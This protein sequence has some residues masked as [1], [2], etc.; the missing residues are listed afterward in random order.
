MVKAKFKKKFQSRKLTVTTKGSLVR[1]GDKIM[2]D[3]F[4]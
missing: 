3:D 1:D 4:L 2:K